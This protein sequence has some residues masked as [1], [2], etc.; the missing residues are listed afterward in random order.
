MTRRFIGWWVGIN[1]VLLI[2]FYHQRQ[3]SLPQPRNWTSL[4]LLQPDGDLHLIK[5]NDGTWLLDNQQVQSA[6]V[7]NIERLMKQECR[8]VFP[9]SEF[10]LTRH[11]PRHFRINTY[12][13]SISNHNSYAEAHYVHHQ[14]EVYLCHER[15]KSLIATPREVWLSQSPKAL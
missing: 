14:G 6:L 10:K 8:H 11:N 5:A 13:Y 12:E 3:P 4:T 1:V 15:L 9:E 2:L 7:E